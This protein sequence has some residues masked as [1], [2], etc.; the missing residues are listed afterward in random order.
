[1]D[2]YGVIKINKD[3]VMK[4][5]WKPIKG[6]E[7]KYEVSNYGLVYSVRRNKLIGSKRGNGYIYVSLKKKQYLVSNIVY[8]TFVG[9]IT[10]GME[11][12][13]IDE[14]KTNNVVW[15]LNLLSHKDNLNWGTAQER[16]II[17]RCKVV[18]QF[19]LNGVLIN[20][21]PSIAEASNNTGIARTNI[22]SVCN[23]RTLTDKKGYKFTNKTAGGYIWKFKNINNLENN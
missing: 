14:D 16:K 22:G 9:P 2:M 13:H 7:G 3:L 23:N 6:F 19:D 4:E 1:M 17:K 20:E 10:E 11:V 12:N 18:Q 8:E 21:Y 15:N 5:I